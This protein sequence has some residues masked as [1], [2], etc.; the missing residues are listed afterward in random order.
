MPQQVSNE[1]GG[2]GGDGD[3]SW[4]PDGASIVVGRV[5]RRA[6]GEGKLTD[7][8]LLV[9]ALRTD[10]VSILPGAKNMWSPRWSPDG[11]FIAGLGGDTSH[12]M[13]YDVK[14]GTQSE[15]FGSGCGIPNWSQDGQFLF[16]N[17]TGGWWRMRMRDRKAELV[18]DLKNISLAGWGW[19]ATAPNNTLITARKT[20]TGGIYALDI[21]W[22]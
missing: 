16:F 6:R 13:L 20:G 18:H 14:T 9:V 15:L 11:R 8:A 12:L 17:S 10:R 2:R 3:P 1:E 22:P 5:P 4:S 19:F 21:D 7:S